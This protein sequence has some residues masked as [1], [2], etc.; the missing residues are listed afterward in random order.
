MT[1]DQ[2]QSAPDPAPIKPAGF[3]NRPFIVKKRHILMAFILLAAVL[4]RF[5]ILGLRV[6]SHDEINHVYFAYNFFKGGEYIHNPI[7]HGPLQ[8]HLLELGYFLFD[9]SDFSAR[10]PAA[11]FSVLTVVFIWRFK[12]YLGKTG[13][14]A[15]SILFVIS[16]IILYYGRYARNEA[17]A[18]FF[19]VVTTWIALRYLDTGK[20][21]YL[22]W[23][24]ALTALHFATKETAFIFTAELMVFLGL[25]F[26]YR[27][28]RLDW[29]KPNYRRLFFILLL[30][31]ALLLLAG[32][33]SGQLL[34]PSEEII[35]AEATTPST[36][37][38][39]LPNYL[40]IAAAAGFLI[41]VVFLVIGFS[42]ALLTKE[43]SFGL[44]LLLL[45]LVLPQLAAFPAS[46]L[47][48]PIT[49][50][51][52]IQAIG[53]VSQIAAVFVV[54]SVI[55]G[56]A[57]KPREWLICAGIYYAIYITLY[58]SIFSNMGGIYSGLIGSL[59]YWLEQQPVE[60]G[61]Q[62]W[63]YFLLIQLPL[64]EYLAMIGTFITGVLS[65][66]WIWR[67]SRN[68]Q[69][70]DL[71]LEDPETNQLSIGNSRKIALAMLLF[72]SI[73]S[74]FAYMVAGEKMPWLTVHISWSMWLL[75][76]WLISRIWDRIRWSEIES[77][78]II[79]LLSAA[80]VALFTLFS[81]LLLWLHTPT[82]FSGR[83]V[84][85]LEATG[86][87]LLLLVLLGGSIYAIYRISNGWTGQR[88]A[89][90]LLFTFLAF[91][92]ILTARHAAL[93]SFKN[94]DLA[95]EYLVY[96]HAARGPKDALEQ[97]ESIS[98]RITGG[99]D[100]QIGF[101]NHTAY[102]FW[103]YL[104]DYPN[105]IEFGEN[106]TRDLRDIPIILVGDS[107]YFKIDP[108]VQ[109]DFLAFEFPRMVW[110]NQDYFNLTFYEDYLSNPETRRPMLNALFQVWLNRDFTAYQA[111]T[112]QDSSALRWS[113]SQ[114]FK[115]FIRKDVAA[116]I[117]QY[118]ASTGSFE[119]EPDLYATNYLDLA[120][121][122]Q[123]SDLGLS[124]A[125]GIA[126]APNGDLYIADTGNNRI[127]HFST[128]LE[129]LGQWGTEGFQTEEFN[130]PWGLAV[131]PDGSVYVADTWNHRIQKF[132]SRGEFITAWGGFGQS[133]DP[134]E[135]W[136]PRDI[137]IDL[138]GQVLVTDTG[139]KR[140]VVFT[141]EGDYVTSFGSVGFSPGEFDEPVGLAISPI[142]GTLFVADTWN[143]RV[144]AFQQIGELGY[145][146]LF[147]WDIDGWYG[148]SLDNK[149][150]LTADPL[151]RVIVADP[152]AGRVLVFGNDGVFL[153]TFG[154]YDPFGPDG[155]GI[156]GGIAADDQGGVWTVD[157]QKNELKYFVV[158]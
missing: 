65:L 63:Y 115:M 124:G 45:T 105:R 28:S 47:K 149:P 127:L 8:F 74:V 1:F 121:I 12:R 77:P 13:A 24:A 96:A 17:F 56:G 49:D 21:K 89:N 125:K 110:P 147:S 79:A 54:A 9:V 52:N 93:A 136:G 111:L 23:I 113:P 50:Y 97:I 44:T 14:Y 62:P 4:S 39:S 92:G 126:V 114:N 134:F 27:I 109:D 51:T 156:I 100:I 69:E 88:R 116:Q 137:A 146:S 35:T 22:Y 128:E 84:A 101:D 95:N 43:R 112:G 73:A 104:R 19:T 143:Q 129:L 32:F 106:P 155:F 138:D 117:W 29:P 60:R 48:L 90:F 20:H 144:Q 76:G 157:S 123:R 99:K 68:R 132:T 6:M 142:D 67:R 46:W 26:L 83:E 148:Q 5:Y 107:N 11:I 139:N 38:S 145:T 53:S 81:A 25:L 87:F 72:F 150:Y 140:V 151:N 80:L 153:S 66:Q 36:L 118:G 18:I 57:W 82:P 119:I 131:G 108:I 16:P 59:G 41:A 158:P 7:T 31:A 120:P 34:S 2:L 58:T 55:L 103:W 154:V 130:Q 141:P 37:S 94:Y 15:A 86:Q 133:G 33:A 3:L 135:F 122:I 102:P 70:D 75:A 61:S 71:F 98:T 152:E 10:V 78:R 91:L 40:L 85:A 30:V 42:W 64:Y